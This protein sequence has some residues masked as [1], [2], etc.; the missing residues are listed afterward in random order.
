MESLQCLNI[1]DIEINNPLKNKNIHDIID[2]NGD[3]MIM[4]L[5]ILIEIKLYKH[6]FLY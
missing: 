4:R 2:C 1:I 6:N 5:I 3:I